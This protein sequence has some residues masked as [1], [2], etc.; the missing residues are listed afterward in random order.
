MYKLRAF[1]PG[2]GL[3]GQASFPDVHREFPATT[4]RFSG[5][6]VRLAGHF[7]PQV[8]AGRRSFVPLPR[9]TTEAEIGGNRSRVPLCTFHLSRS[10]GA[11]SRSRSF[12]RRAKK[13]EL[14]RSLRR[15]PAPSALS[16]AAQGGSG[17]TRYYPSEDNGRRETFRYE[18]SRPQ[19]IRVPA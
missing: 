2:D 19:I 17:I 7:P 15:R 6:Q 18:H 10:F 5:A 13:R 16:R 12:V 1:V 8:C 4:A 11:P 14:A 9:L 3:F